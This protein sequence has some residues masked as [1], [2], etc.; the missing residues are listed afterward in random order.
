LLAALWK[1]SRRAEG[2]YASLKL[3]EAATASC[4]L[5]PYIAN[6]ALR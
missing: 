1:A 3:R 6:L 2:E 4:A 5:D